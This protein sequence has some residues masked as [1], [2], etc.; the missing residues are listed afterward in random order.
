MA[1]TLKITLFFSIF[2]IFFLSPITSNPHPL[3]S[4]TPSEF[5]LVRTIV[6]QSYPSPN[7]KLTFRYVGLEEPEKPVVK[8]WLTTPPTKP[9]PRQ[10]LVVIRLNQQTR[11]LIVDLS[12]RSIVSDELYDGFGYPL[13]T[14][15]EEE[16]A[17]DL[18]LKHEPFL[19]SIKRRG[20]NISEVVCS[21]QTIGWYG[22]VKTGRELKVICFYLNGTVNMYLRP[23]EGITIVV[24]IE[25]MKI[26]EYVDRAVSP[27]AKAEG[28]EYRASKIRPPFGPRFKAAPPTP[29]GQLGFTLDGNV[30]S[31]ANWKFHLGF[32][33]RVGPVI[34]L[35]SIYDVDKKKYRQVVYRSFISELF[36]PY[37]DPTEEWYHISFFD[38]GEFGFGIYAVSLEPLNDCTSNA[39]FVNGYYAGQDGKPVKVPDVMC[40]FERHS[41]DVMWRHTEAELRDQKVAL[42]G[43]LEV[44]AVPYTHI[45]EI[46]EEVYGTLVADNTIGVSHDHFLTYHLDLDIDGDTNSFIKTHLIT[47]QVKD[48]NIPRKSYWNVEHEIAKTESDAKLQIGLNPPE[49][50]VVNSYKR[51][52]TG[53]KVGY[54]LVPGS[55]VGPLLAA[56]D[57]PQIR[58]AFTNYNVWVTPYNKSEKWAGGRYVDQSRGDDT[59]AVWTENNRSI[60]N[61]DIVLWYTMGFHH[62]PCQ[63]DFPIMPTLSGG[64]EIKPTNFF[65]YSPV[66][67]SFPP[68]HTSW[69]N[70]TS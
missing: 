29:P 2:T 60:E 50:L 48:K 39:V 24:D 44:K 56:D 47:K 42:T 23:I 28:T 16:A 43:V 49:L 27:L 3:D 30:V 31:W 35:A 20:L 14:R 55:A 32:D 1:S 45:D 26:S 5:L 17:A 21:T 10:A 66:L 33:A 67:K 25:Q 53:N 59:L 61:K 41:G 22:E 11:E 13:L 70:C 19:A 8:S 51:T 38:C 40:I 62:V 7:H 65:E 68:Q 4:L 18:A 69:P 57:Y 12:K 52:K 37:Q 15:E 58:A 46:T 9:P 54:R 63:E 6:S 64:F 36:V 34:S